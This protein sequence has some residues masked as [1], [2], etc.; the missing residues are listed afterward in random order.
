MSAV[1]AIARRLPSV[2][3]VADVIFASP[4]IK[5]LAT[6]LRPFTA[7]FSSS[8]SLVG[9][10]VLLTLQTCTSRSHQLRISLF[11]DELPIV[12][13]C[14]RKGNDR[15]FSNPNCPRGVTIGDASGPTGVN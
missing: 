7:G 8:S 5:I 4:L 11:L 13:S 15:W 9:T 14:G 1:V 2:L 10:A 3:R 12:S 6:S